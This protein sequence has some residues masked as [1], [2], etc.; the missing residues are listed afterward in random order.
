MLPHFKKGVFNWWPHVFVNSFSEII[1]H[2]LFVLNLIKYVAYSLSITCAS[3]SLFLSACTRYCLLAFLDFLMQNREV[4]GS[5]QVLM[6]ESS[7]VYYEAYSKSK[8]SWSTIS[9]LA[10]QFLSLST[11]FKS[12][13]KLKMWNCRGVEEASVTLW[14]VLTTERR[15]CGKVK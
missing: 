12:Q 5:T 15:L 4:C 7:N 14:K 9:A 8:G 6:V 3:F 2:E 13:S 11:G 1:S 10:H